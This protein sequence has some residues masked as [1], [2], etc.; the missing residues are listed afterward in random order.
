V[1]TPIGQLIQT[2]QAGDPQAASSLFAALYRE[3]HTIAER[4]L[5][6]QGRDL[7]LGTTTLL[8]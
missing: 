4:E 6:R 7:T 5:Q 1:D 8:H 3:L 2:A